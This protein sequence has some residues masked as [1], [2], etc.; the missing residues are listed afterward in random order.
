MIIDHIHQHWEIRFKDIDPDTGD[1]SQDLP[2]AIT[3]K[4][5]YANTIMHALNRYSYEPNREYYV[6]TRNEQK[7]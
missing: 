2:V 6:M 1:I 5:E 7:V 3:T 4:E